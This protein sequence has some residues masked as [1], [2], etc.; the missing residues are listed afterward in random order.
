MRKGNRTGK[1]K[2]RVMLEALRWTYHNMKDLSEPVHNPKIEKTLSDDDSLQNHHHDGD[3]D[4]E[5]TCTSSKF[6]C[7]I[8]LPVLVKQVT[9]CVEIVKVVVPQI[10]QGHSS[11]DDTDKGY[12]L[13]RKNR[14]YIMHKHTQLSGFYTDGGDPRDTRTPL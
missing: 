12:Q 1:V 4:E 8:P 9:K 10:I 13:R 2:G 11:S 3:K 7:V 6:G 14:G 5:T